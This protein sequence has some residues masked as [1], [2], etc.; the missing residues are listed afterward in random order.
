MKKIQDFTWKRAIAYGI[1]TEL[2]LVALQ[3]LY[4]N[5]YAAMNPEA[6]VVFN[7]DYMMSAGF[8]IFQ[9]IGFFVYAI[10]VYMLNSR[11]RI[12]SLKVIL[13]YLITGGIIELTFYL[14]IQ[15]EYQG[16]F[17]YSILDKFVAAVFGS[18]VYFYTT[19][20]ESTA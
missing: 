20:K 17:L 14:I 10:T 12:P 15:A 11:Y 13:T 3:L 2:F 8:Y 7:A 19:G 18:I 4:L 1:V 16:V 9:I 5:V 6:N